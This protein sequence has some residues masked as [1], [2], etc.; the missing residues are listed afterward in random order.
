MLFADE[1]LRLY[2]S[3]SAKFINFSPI[4][5]N[6]V[7]MYVCGPTVYSRPHLGNAR[8]FILYDVL[9]RILKQIYPNITYV[10]NITDVDDK[11]INEAKKIGKTIDEVTTKTIQEFHEDV[12]ALNCLSP[13]FEPRA[14]ENISEMIEII[15][16]LIFKKHAYI[17]DNHVL[18][19]VKTFDKYCCLSKKIISDLIIG[20]R[21]EVENYKNNDQDF[22]LWKPV[23]KNEYGF[24]SKFG[25]G[26]PGWHIECSAMSKKY[27]GDEFDIHGG[28]ADLKFP[29]HDNEIAQSMC[30]SE[31]NFAKYWIHN[32]FLMVEGEKMSKSLG[33]FITPRD[34][35]NQGIHPEVI[36]FILLS[37]LYSRPLD[38]T[39][40]L[41]LDGNIAMQKFYKILS[42]YNSLDDKNLQI[43]EL[44]KIAILDN[45]NIPKYI[46]IM[47][48]LVRNINFNC[49]ELEK[50]KL[51]YQLYSM[52][53]LIGIFTIKPEIFLNYNRKLDDTIPQHILQ[54]ANDRRNCK[55]QKDF[56]KA[57]EIK[58]NIEKLGYIIKDLSDSN[59][60]IINTIQ[61]L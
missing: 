36:R 15:N 39:K 6:N 18:F 25:Y 3:L 8:S 52:G 38:F 32:G 13:N 34:L 19:S 23:E 54:L 48:S 42:E 17:K 41:I 57:D 47:H 21:V 50:Q 51:A 44:A 37:N 55:I 14:T 11:I 12:R 56:K 49:S 16:E 58:K 7:K 28:G 22:V 4:D 31:K 43:P 29:H 1:T 59:F 10:R 35:I 33:N 2:D 26:R 61:K 5:Q 27:L 9:F 24:E 46:A 45:L 30:S 20:A 53:V 40:K 60:E